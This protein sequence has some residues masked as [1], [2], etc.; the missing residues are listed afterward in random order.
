MS[1]YA[2]RREQGVI[3][4][5][6]TVAVSAA[7]RGHRGFARVV[8]ALGMITLTA[9]LFWLLTD[10]AFRVTEADVTFSGLRHAD[11][12]EVR[13]Y[14]ADLDRAPNVFRVRANDIVAELSGLIEVDAAAASVTLPASV[15][16]E[17]DE[18]EPVFIWSDGEVSWLVDDT[19][20]LFAPAD[21]PTAVSDTQ[22]EA[23]AA[24][25]AEAKADAPTEGEGP[26]EAQAGSAD[27]PA[28]V[29]V[30]TAARAALPMVRDARQP[31][32]RPTV[33]STLA[34]IDMAVMRQLLALTPE[35]L[36]SRSEDLRLSVDNVDGYVLESRDL[37]WDALFG[38]Y[39]PT[40]Q[41]PDR[42]PR[43]VQCL[44]SLLARAETELE[45]A[46]LAVGERTCGTY[47]AAEPKR[48]RQG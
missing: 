26:A 44:R 6:S 20:T 15:S 19:G 21:D 36:G 25:E 47:R 5:R 39:T 7:R 8:G 10:D 13:S 32:P 41:P 42:V 29:D 45:R 23:P 38:H 40:L 31:D 2:S 33:G 34:A 16:V 18:R 22:A 35:L 9:L 27:A 46:W 17:L 12:A 43:Q 37:G 30:R 1:R 48:D 11:E 14:L 28:T 3:V 4:P 24:A